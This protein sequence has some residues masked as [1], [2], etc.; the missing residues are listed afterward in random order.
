LSLT[1]KY[2]LSFGLIVGLTVS[3]KEHIDVR[4]VESPVASRADAVGF[5]Y[6]PVIPSTHC[7]NMHVEKP[8]YLPCGQ[9]TI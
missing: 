4:L 7:V 9:Q 8:G 6:A 3:S 2:E 5:K 1:D